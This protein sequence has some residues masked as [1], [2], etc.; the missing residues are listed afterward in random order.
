M[1]ADERRGEVAEQRRCGLE[2][3]DGDIEVRTKPADLG[4]NAQKL[5]KGRD[6]SESR[7]VAERASMQLGVETRG[8]EV[9]VGRRA[10]RVEHV[11][12]LGDV[13]ATAA[14]EACEQARE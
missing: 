5:K 12:G 13:L 6:V 3:F 10:G 9:G 2:E 11:R 7:K 1:A 8:G 4:S 14:P